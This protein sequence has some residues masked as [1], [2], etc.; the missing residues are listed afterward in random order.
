MTSSFAYPIPLPDYR[1]RGKYARNYG[2]RLIRWLIRSEYRRLLDL[3]RAGKAPSLDVGEMTGRFEDL[4]VRNAAWADYDERKDQWTIDAREA[5]VL[6]G[7]AAAFVAEHYEP[8]YLARAARGGRRSRRRP[9]FTVRLLRGLE[10]LS[11]AAQAAALGCSTSTVAGLR[12]ELARRVRALL[13]K[14]PRTSAEFLRVLLVQDDRTRTA[15]RAKCRW[16]SLEMLQGARR[17]RAQL[18]AWERV[19]L[20]V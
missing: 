5:G 14:H 11:K 19:L 17:R 1:N 4:L 2:G 3:N 16:A 10:A 20:T 8:E 18:V 12:R 15:K 6:A 9:S 13:A 7:K